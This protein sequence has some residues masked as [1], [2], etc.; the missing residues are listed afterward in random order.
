MILTLAAVGLLIMGG[1]CIYAYSAIDYSVDEQLFIQSKGEG[2]TRLFY[3]SGGVDEYV[4]SEYCYLSASETKRLWC[5]YDEAGDRIKHAFIATE[6][7]GF[8]DHHGIDVKRTGFA[9][10]NYILKLKPKFGG[11]T[12]TQQVIKNISGDNEQTVRRKISE[13]MRAYHIESIY[14]KEDIFEVYLNIV[15]MG[16]G[17][18]GIGYASQYYFGKDPSELTNSEAATLVGITNA[19]SRY[20]PYENP[21]QCKEKRNKVLYAMRECGYITDAEYEIACKEDIVL[22][23]REKNDYVID[24]WFAET[25]L[26]DVGRDLAEKMEISESVARLLILRGGYSIHTTVNPLIQKKLELYFADPSNFPEKIANG[27]NFSFVVADSSSGDLIGIIGSVGNKAANRVVNHAT[28]PHTPGSSLK[29]LA[30]YAPA[31]DE[32]YVNWATV[33]D[34]VPV[35]F[36]ELSD[37]TLRPYPKN[38]PDVYDG[39][40]TLA[41][42]LRMSKNTVA[43]RLYNMLGKDKIFALLEDDFGFSTLIAGKKEKNGYY[44]DKAA[45]PLALGQLTYGV[46]LRSLTSAY[47]VFPGEGNFRQSRSYVALYDSQGDLIIDNKPKEK[48]IFGNDTAQIMNLMLSQVITSGTAS[49]ITLPELLDAAGKTGT[50]GGDKDRLFVGYTPYYTAGIWCGYSDAGQSI[51]YQEISH[52]EIW[53]EIMWDLHRDIISPGEE[54]DSFSTSGLDRLAFCKDSGK[55]FIGNCGLDP[56]GER[57]SYGYF[58]RSNVPKGM[59]DRHVPCLY[60]NETGAIA[61]EKCP[62]DELSLISLIEVNDRAFPIEI[63]ITDAEYVWRNVP[64]GTAFG[65]SYDLP[66]F[67]NTVADGSFVGRSKTKKQYNSSCYLHND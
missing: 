56:R 52:L 53:D 24:S 60:D 39:L 5:P 35:S 48:R 64:E 3:N 10:V 4:P 41:D 61:T 13:I 33:F 20:D 23:A 47:T 42:A 32:G 28:V 26:D 59:C 9:I 36:S 63:V 34:D 8:F 46:S 2:I 27:L 21:L 54:P 44:T 19:P 67:I 38:Y 15:P 50:S 7:R 1:L 25:V 65:D 14:S 49:R 18:C 16:D 66:F 43:M 12:I 58:S 62:R 45:A 57:L 55:L 29:P 17:V 40:T 22:A 37:G 31:I 11:S 6:D 51:G 30:L